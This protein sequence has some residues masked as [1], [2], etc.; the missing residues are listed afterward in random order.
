MI[1]FLIYY[2]TVG[3]IAA[4]INFGI[5]FAHLQ[6]QWPSIAESDL[7]SDYSFSGIMSLTTL[8]F[9]LTLF[10]TFFMWD[11]AKHGLKFKK[12]LDTPKG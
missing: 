5:T 3:V 4:I 7:E 12:E 9:P 2:F 11:C 6:R 1:T 8:V 10:V